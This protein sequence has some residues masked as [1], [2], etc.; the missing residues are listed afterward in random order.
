VRK[1]NQAFGLLSRTPG[2]GQIREDLT[3]RDVKFWTVFS[4]MIVYDPAKRPIEIVRVLHGNRDLL[5]LLG[6]DDELARRSHTRYNH[7][8]YSI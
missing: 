2:A 4:Y 3:I 6:S 8:E 5:R 1:I 7:P